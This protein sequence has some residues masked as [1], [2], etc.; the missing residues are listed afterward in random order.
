MILGQ[1]FPLSLGRDCHQLQHKW[2]LSS[3]KLWQCRPLFAFVL[4]KRAW[5][6]VLK[7]REHEKKKKKKAIFE[8]FGSNLRISL[9]SSSKPI[10]RIRS[11]SSIM[12]H[13]RLEKLNP[14]V[15]CFPI[16]SEKEKEKK[17]TRGIKERR[18]LQMVQQ[19]TGCANEKIDSS[20]QLFNF[21]TSGCTSND[22]SVCK[23][24][25]AEQFVCNSIDLN[26]QFSRG[27]DNNHSRAFFRMP[28][29]S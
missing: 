3:G 14:L 29:L 2:A 28:I 22:D 24:E 11:A 25:I 1:E 21:S 8:P 16:G 7:G 4:L 26:R 17:Q 5:I 6:V 23:S 10:S 13:L 12:R 27:C 19:T 15:F 9:I 18:Y 20:L